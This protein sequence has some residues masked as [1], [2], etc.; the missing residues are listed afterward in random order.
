[1][2]VLGLDLETSGLDPKSDKIIE[3]GAILWDC[4]KAKPIQILSELV[5]NDGLEVSEL[6]QKLTGIETKD[7]EDFGK[8]AEEVLEKLKS[9][10]EKAEYVVAHNGK[11]FDRLFMENYWN[12]FS[13][14]RIGLPWMDTMSDLP[15]PENMSTRKLTH[16]ASEHQFLNPFAHRAVFDVMTMMKIFSSYRMSDILD[17]ALSE[18]KR[19]VAKVSFDEKELAKKE[20]FRWDPGQ[21]VWYKDVKEVQLKDMAFPFTID[22]M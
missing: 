12:E 5:K 16:L 14:T 2:Y 13:N 9:M 7:L 11:N 17:L 18:T 3:V 10:S 19:V 22:Y 20:G 6:I 4:E 21:K 8:P 15:Y 1:M